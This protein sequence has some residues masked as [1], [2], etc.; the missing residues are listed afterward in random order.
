[1]I[2]LSFNKRGLFDYEILEKFEAGL[3]LKGFEVKSIRNGHANLR[4]SF[5][6]I[7][8][9]EIYLTNATVSPY[10][11]QNTPTDY[12]PARPRKLLLREKE[13]NYLIGKVKQK[14]LTLVPTRIYDKK[15]YLKLEFGVAKGK[16]KYDKRESIKK[17]EFKQKTQ[18]MIKYQ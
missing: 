5:V 11:S 1:M 9:G 6:T 2:D 12:D 15:G 13:I 7:K 16:K 14:G 3:M 4:G 17:R 18:R 8:G 10:Q